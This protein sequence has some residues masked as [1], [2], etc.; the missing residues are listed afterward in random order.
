[1]TT[2]PTTKA[3][4]IPRN[5]PMSSRA[6]RANRWSSPVE[7]TC[8][9]R[10]DLKAGA[11]DGPP[12]FSMKAYRG[13]KLKLGTFPHPVYVETSGVEI[14]GG[15]ETLPILRDHDTSRPVGHGTPT[16]EANALAIDGSISLETDDARDVIKASK[17]GF[18]W[19]ASIGG[20]I[21]GKPKFIQAGRS[22][23]V[24]GR[25]V[26]G[27]AYIVGSFLWQETSVVSVGAD[28]DRASTSIAASKTRKGLDMEFSQWLADKNFDESQ[29]DDSQLDTLRASYKLEQSGGVEQQLAE[30]KA[31][32][33]AADLR[34]EYA[35]VTEE[36]TAINRIGLRYEG[37]VADETLDSLRAQAVAGEIDSAKFEL[38][39]L[40]Q[41]RPMA[42]GS[43]QTARYSGANAD[44]IV[45]SLC[46]TMG[47]EENVI[48]ASMATE[49]GKK[50][51]EKAMDDAAK[52]KGFSLHKLLFAC[53]GANGVSVQPGTHVDSEVLR[54]AYQAS[55]RSDQTS[56]QASAGFSTISIPGI[57]SRVA[58]KAMLQA[59]GE[60]SGV[61]TTIASES[62]T[63]DLKQFDRYRMTEAGVM[64]ETGSTGE[65]KSSTLTEEMHQNQVVTHAIKFGISEDMMINDDMGALL[66]IPRL[67]GR[68]AAHTLE[69]KVIDMLVDAASGAG[70]A[71][72]FFYTDS[73]KKNKPNY[74]TTGSALDIDTLGTANQLFLDQVD[75]E[76]KP[77]NVEPALLLVTTKNATNAG[78]LWNDASYR[79]TG[80][81]TKEGIENQWK[82][83]FRPLVSPYL[84]SR[85]TT[86]NADQWYLLPTPSD[87]AAL[88]IAYLRGMRVPR[89]ESSDVDFS[90]LGMEMRGVF[91]FGV[92]LWDRRLAV[93]ASG[94]AAA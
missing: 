56:L 15:A 43:G 19:Q 73:T 5:N 86:A 90:Q 40:K 45:A 72:N 85:G 75:S 50:A 59:Y 25:N 74:F 62:D 31:Q 35:R 10:L 6:K 34:S 93:K 33:S 29:F 3:P 94:A 9:A 84:G 7:F 8:D 47:M 44:A 52:L 21:Q 68:M 61:A 46:Q 70:A 71:T 41:S 16:I 80:S 37:K 78:K 14:H 83:R 42:T 54:A 32:N 23:R 66:Q 67:L 38:E 92:A 82:G 79:F 91:R 55:V 49:L 1:M 58:N 51:G 65:I 12:A 22:T 69:Q 4:T 18:P 20:Q 64:L 17:N 76:G 63:T 13:G 30:L 77:I 26:P 28:I 81:D 48:E 36:M 11:D 24:N 53:L 89:I 2:K 60:F 88:N 39:L 57:L 27:P 87:T